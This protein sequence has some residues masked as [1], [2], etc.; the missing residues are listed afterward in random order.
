MLYNY[1][2][3]TLFKVRIIQDSVFNQGSIQTEFTV[4]A[5]QKLWFNNIHICIYLFLN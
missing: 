3:E 2:I 1:Y 5:Y 4:Q